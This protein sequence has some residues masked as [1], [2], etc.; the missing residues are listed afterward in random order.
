MTD[1]SMAKPRGRLVIGG[2]SLLEFSLPV[3]WK[4]AEKEPTGCGKAEEA[5]LPTKVPDDNDGR[6]RALLVTAPPA[7]VTPSCPGLL[8]CCP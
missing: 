3:L 6:E 5:P 7:T 2:G 1:A 8:R 4:R